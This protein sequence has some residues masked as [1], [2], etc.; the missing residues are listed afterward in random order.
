MVAG[1]KGEG[2]YGK[3]GSRAREFEKGRK[4][5]WHL[6]GALTE[7]LSVEPMIH[8]MLKANPTPVLMALLTFFFF[9]IVSC[10]SL[11]CKCL[12][13]RASYCFFD[14]WFGVTETCPCSQGLGWV[15]SLICMCTS[16]RL[17]APL[18]Q[19]AGPYFCFA[20]DNP[21]WHHCIHFLGHLLPPL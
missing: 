6:P 9:L 14:R 16:H 3:L 8:F 4:T 19:W 20:G 1:P 21:T 12:Q 5:W 18:G 2:V 17:H 7:V 11:A 15:C 10:L 13:G